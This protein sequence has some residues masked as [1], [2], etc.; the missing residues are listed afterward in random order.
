MSIGGQFA[1]GGRISE[2]LVSEQLNKTL[3]GGQ[4]TGGG[5]MSRS[6]V[7]KW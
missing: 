7:S 5:R 2:K 4:L 6:S 1:S 3:I